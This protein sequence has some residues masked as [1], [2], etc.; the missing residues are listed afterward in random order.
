MELTIDSETIRKSPQSYGCFA[1]FV[2]VNENWGFKFFDSPRT[3][4]KNYELN[5]RAGE[6]GLAPKVGSKIDFP[7]E[8]MFGFFVELIDV[9]IEN[10]PAYPGDNWWLDEW[11]KDNDNNINFDYYKLPNLISLFEEI[12]IS[13]GDLHC[14]NVGWMK[15]GTFVCIDFSDANFI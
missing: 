2:K 6:C 5:K 14:E 7:E 15:D 12:G 4:D 8:S 13:I 9:I 1:K 3:R 11:K 10:H